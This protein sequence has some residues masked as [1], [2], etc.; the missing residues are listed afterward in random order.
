MRNKWVIVCVLIIASLIT[1]KISCV[2][3]ANKNPEKDSRE[4]KFQDML[5]LFLLPYM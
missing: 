3:A 1:F 4:L 5:V 2:A